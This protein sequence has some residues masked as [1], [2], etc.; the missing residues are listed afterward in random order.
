MS[1]NFSIWGTDGWQFL[2]SFLHDSTGISSGIP[3]YNL[4]IVRAINAAIRAENRANRQQCWMDGNFVGMSGRCESDPSVGVDKALRQLNGDTQFE[5]SDLRRQRLEGYLANQFY[6]EWGE[7]VESGQGSNI[8]AVINKYGQYSDV[9]ATNPFIGGLSFNMASNQDILNRMILGDSE[10]GATVQFCTSTVTTNCVDPTAVRDLWEDVGRHV[11]IIFKGLEIPGLPEWLPIPG[12]MSLPTIGEIFDK[13][14]G[15]FQDEADR[16]MKDCLSR[17]DDMDGVPNT[18]S[19]CIE[20]RDITSIITKTVTGAASD[21]IDEAGRK[22]R[23]ILD[24]DL[25]V[26]CADDPQA[27]AD[28]VQEILGDIFGGVWDQADPTMPGIPDWVRAIIIAGEYGDEVIRGIE[29]ATNTDINNDGTIGLTGEDN[30]DCAT[31]GRQG[32]MVESENQCGECLQGYEEING[33]CQEEE[34]PITN[35]GPTAADCAVEHR[36]FNPA[37][38]VEDSSCGACLDGWTDENGECV[39]DGTD[40]GVDD[41]TDDGT[42]P[43][44]NSP[45]PSFDGTFDSQYAGKAWDQ[46]CQDTNCPQD[47][48]LISDHIDNDCNQGLINDGSTECDNGATVESE[49]NQC[50]GNNTIPDWHVDGDCRNPVTYSGDPCGENGEVYNDAGECVPA[51]EGGCP[52]GSEP[53]YQFNDLDKSGYFQFGGQWYQYDPCNPGAGQTPVTKCGDGSFEEN[54]N[55]CPVSPVEECDNGATNYPDCDQCPDGQSLENGQCVGQVQ[56]CDNGATVES[57]CEE[58]PEG[59]EFNEQGICAQAYSCDDPN[60]TVITNGPYAGACGPCKPGYVYDGAP[61][62]CVKDGCPEGEMMGPD[63]VC[64]NT[65]CPEGQSFCEDT[66]QCENIGDCPSDGDEGGNTGGGFSGSSGGGSMFQPY[67]FA[68]SSDPQLLS[69]SEFPITDFL[70]GVFT[71]STGGRNV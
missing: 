55:D 12:I 70:A 51:G 16:Q 39:E 71:N 34:E 10:W 6:R 36:E 42:G 56:T 38:D 32:G 52:D 47:G 37:T 35:Q 29:T 7:A 28:K 19:Y 33:Q 43:D 4:Q 5:I 49:C 64:V 57:G 9:M 17:D 62:R 8:Q 11:Q 54:E 67:S 27:C 13:V 66:G 31:V 46:A 45:R 23:E 30:F 68:I 41:G 63:G 48:S 21:V 60:A 26:P 58:C 14:V 18:A 61:E 3:G 44:C 22:I 59:F 15:P 50:P 25:E 20:S 40:G 65:P 1:T 53:Q 24:G 2:V 69:R